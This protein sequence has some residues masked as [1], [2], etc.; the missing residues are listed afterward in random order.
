VR[1][2]QKTPGKLDYR[3]EAFKAFWHKYQLSRFGT[4]KPMAKVDPHYRLRDAIERRRFRSW[5]QVFAYR[6]W[7]SLVEYL[8]VESVARRLELYRRE[9]DCWWLTITEVRLSRSGSG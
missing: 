6:Q 9:L 3:S 8:V 1:G 2:G 7:P 5:Q 4:E